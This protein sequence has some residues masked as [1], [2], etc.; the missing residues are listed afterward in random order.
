MMGVRESRELRKSRRKGSGRATGRRKRM[1]SAP[2]RATHGKRT[3]GLRRSTCCRANAQPSE[4]I[5]R[6]DEELNK[7]AQ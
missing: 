5:Q 4:E 1:H 3:L 6:S 7:A 2:G